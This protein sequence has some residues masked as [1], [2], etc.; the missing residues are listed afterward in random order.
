MRR[1]LPGRRLGGRA[2]NL[3]F[4]RRA[5]RGEGDLIAFGELDRWEPE[6]RGYELT[7]AAMAAAHHGIAIAIGPML[8][9]LAL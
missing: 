1:S 4:T 2:R 3:R 9:E 5:D 8:D 7:T 6:V